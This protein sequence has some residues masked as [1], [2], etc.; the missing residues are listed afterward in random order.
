MENIS[1]NIDLASNHKI[2]LGFI[3]YMRQKGM[4]GAG[5]EC[6]TA[7]VLTLMVSF[8]KLMFRTLATDSMITIEVT[9]IVVNCL[10]I[11]AY[12]KVCHSYSLF[13]LMVE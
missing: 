11:F 12:T 9:Y 5:S 10:Q 13:D 3:E 4:V 2:L 1:R 8:D 7:P 6:H